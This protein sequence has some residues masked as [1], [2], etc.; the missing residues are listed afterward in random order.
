MLAALRSEDPAVRWLAIHVLGARAA[1]EEGDDVTAAL[2]AA[3]ADTYSAVR[4]LAAENLRSIKD[5]KGWQEHPRTV[6]V[7]LANALHDRNPLVRGAARA[8]LE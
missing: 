7:V 2:A 6:R 3:L 8:A 5:R 1:D 4:W